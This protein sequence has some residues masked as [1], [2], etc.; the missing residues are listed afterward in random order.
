MKLNIPENPRNIRVSTY[1]TA[2]EI[3]DLCKVVGD[4]SMAGWLRELVLSEIRRHTVAEALGPIK[5][6]PPYG[7]PFAKC[8]CED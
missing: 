1:L 3:A 8:N 7:Y 2:E 6:A 4:Q 5:S